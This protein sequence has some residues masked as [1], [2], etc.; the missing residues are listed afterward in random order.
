[1][2]ACA[3][4]PRDRGKGGIQDTCGS[5]QLPAGICAPAVMSGS[6]L[7]CRV[8]G[9]QVRC[10]VCARGHTRVLVHPLTAGVCNMRCLEG[11]VW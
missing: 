1:M 2:L 9:R 4:R 7:Q 11:H 8:Q 5:Q 10:A 6:G 3:G